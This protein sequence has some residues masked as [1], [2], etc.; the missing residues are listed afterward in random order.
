MAKK[1]KSNKNKKTA[2]SQRPSLDFDLSDLIRGIQVKADFTILDP[3]KVSRKTY[4]RV[5]YP[6]NNSA[7]NE[8]DDMAAGSHSLFEPFDPSKIR[9]SY[10]ELPIDLML[11]RIEQKDLQLNP[12]F[13]RS[14]DIWTNDAQSR[15][16][17]SVLIRIPLPVFYIDG[18]EEDSW[19][20]VDGLQRLN[21]FKKFA[22]DNTL[23]LQN[24]EFLKDLHGNTFQTLPRSLQR[25]FMETTI[26]IYLIEKGTPERVKLSI[27]QRINTGGLPLSMQEIRHAVYQGN[28]S[29]FLNRLSESEDFKKVIGNRIS[30]ERMSDREALL[31]ATAFLMED[32]RAYDNRDLEGFL[33]TTMSRLQNLESKNLEN[34]FARIIRSLRIADKISGAELFRKPSGQNEKV[35]KVNKSLFDAWMVALDKTKDYE[36]DLL[37]DRK[38]QLLNSYKRLFERNQSFVSAISSGTG[39]IKNIQIRFSTI[40]NL[41]KEILE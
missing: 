28:A 19:I 23:K 15:L 29:R 27:F 30:K 33:N 21:T 36:A 14:A 7:F 26:G 25:R 13:Q 22:L 1:T 4:G 17:E 6:G 3:T 11:K 34:L 10:K 20:V 40:E 9:V 41:V 31:R 32:Y 8:S 24:L 39:D 35:K 38:R 16:I 12:D 2:V 37:I 5:T 18:S